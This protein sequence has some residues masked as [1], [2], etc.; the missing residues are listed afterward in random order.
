MRRKQE[1]SMNAA[2]NRIHLA[3]RDGIHHAERDDY[4]REQDSHAFSRKGRGRERQAFTL[5]ELLVVIAIIGVLA[6]LLLPAVHGAREASRFAT[7]QSNLRQIGIALADFG[8]KKNVFCSGAFD[9]HLDGAVTEVGWVADLVNSGINVG[10][11]LCPSNRRQL[12]DTYNDLLNSAIDGSGNMTLTTGITDHCR[13]ILRLGSAPAQSALDGSTLVNPCRQIATNATFAPGAPA[14]IDLVTRQIYAKG[15]NTN[16]TASWF[17]VRGGLLLDTNGNITTSDAT[18]CA[19]SL[20]SPA[21]TRGPLSPAQV[22]NA[23]VGASQIPLMG[24]GGVS[25]TLTMPFGPSGAPTNVTTPSLTGG[26]VLKAAVASPYTGSGPTMGVPTF[27]ASTARTG[28][29]GWWTV[30]NN[31]A[32]QDYRQFGPVHRGI[33]NVLFADGSVRTLSDNNNDGYL[34]D[35]FPTTGSN[36]FTDNFNVND[37]DAVPEVPPGQ[38]YGGWSLQPKQQ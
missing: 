22:D 12:A 8:G 2:G 16:Y 37:P 11:M 32:L 29:A 17:L 3:P 38:M 13:S 24:D 15:Y 36:G 30:W 4:F 25:V 5:V 6:A 7:C 9:W 14:R 27:P 34:N 28:A 23:S 21:S 26:P 1:K 31:L 19:A 18:N 33:A 10:S 35:G 20:S